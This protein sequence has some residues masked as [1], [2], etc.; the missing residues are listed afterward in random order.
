MTTDACSPAQGCA[1]YADT[2]YVLL[3]MVI[4]SHACVQP[5]YLMPFQYLCET[6][7]DMA[8]WV[9]ASIVQR[10]NY[11]EGADKRP[12]ILFDGV[13]NMCAA[14]S[15]HVLNGLPPPVRLARIACALWELCV[16]VA[17]C[18]KQL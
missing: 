12:I 6:T 8:W 13:C 11:F 1:A 9:Q 7:K 16:T 14:N 3:N 17:C 5:Q 15:E 2:C 4:D 10:K 18:R